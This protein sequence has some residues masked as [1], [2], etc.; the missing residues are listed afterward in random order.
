[1][2]N[3]RFLWVW[4]AITALCI[5]LAFGYGQKWPEIKQSTQILLAGICFF[6]LFS[7]GQFYLAK[8]HTAPKYNT[9]F[10]G[11]FFVSIFVKLV[12][13]IALLF[14]YQEKFGLIPRSLLGLFIL[15]YV[16]YLILETWYMVILGKMTS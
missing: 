5:T 11:L 12:G 7:L 1:M 16:L 6:S 15:V 9:A 8:M 14:A 13:A 3:S 4:A 10:I 2:S